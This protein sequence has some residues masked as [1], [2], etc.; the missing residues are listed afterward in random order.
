MGA[1]RLQRGGSR[2][3]TQL[4]D[5]SAVP[6]QLWVRGGGELRL[7]ALRSVAVVGARNCTPYGMAVADRLAA[8]LVAAGW[9]VISGAAYG[10]DSAAHRGA[11]AA[12]GCTVA[13][14]AGGIDRAVAGSAARLLDSIGEQGL[15]VAEQP[16][17]AP[18]LRHSF[19]H[20]NRIIAALARA[21]V[22]VEAAERSGALNTARTAEG[23][24]RVVLAVP[25]PVTGGM[26]RGTHALIRDGRAVLARDT[27]DV[28]EMVEAIGALPSE[29]DNRVFRWEKG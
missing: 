7:L 4:E 15:V 28:L 12:G 8:E 14:V 11:V 18:A 19:L 13:V 20:R 25:G 21:T 26:S 16:G 1:Q 22:V 2:W 17:E 10:I 23:L 3:P 6:E 24:G 29:A 5:L 27:A 9:V